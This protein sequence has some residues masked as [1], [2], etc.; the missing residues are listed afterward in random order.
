M[1]QI[2][3]NFENNI[4]GRNGSENIL[5]VME[6]LTRKPVTFKKMIDQGIFSDIMKK[7]KEIC[8]EE[9]STSDDEESDNE[10]ES[11]D[12]KEEEKLPLKRNT[13][14]RK[15][16]KISDEL[17]CFI[18]TGEFGF[19]TSVLT[20]VKD[21]ITNR[22][23]LQLLFILYSIKNKMAKDSS[24][25]QIITATPL[26][27]SCFDKTFKLMKEKN[28]NFNPESFKYS[29]F[30]SIIQLNISH[31]DLNENDVDTLMDKLDNDRILVKN[32]IELERK[33]NK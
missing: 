17:K 6:L 15:V 16:V 22:A 27:Y 2:I 4:A 13:G 21:G 14:F 24:K 11:D 28:S 1:E 33:Q 7:D 26:M 20:A 9:E 5:D 29:M 18:S 31:F 3:S 19:D 25:K 32:Y 8:N 10:A 23:N 12:E 30:Q